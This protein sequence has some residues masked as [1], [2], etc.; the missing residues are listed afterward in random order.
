MLQHI[1]VNII[2]SETADCVLLFM[3]FLPAE[4]LEETSIQEQSFA[5]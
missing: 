4:F 2:A 5:N 1:T 3:S